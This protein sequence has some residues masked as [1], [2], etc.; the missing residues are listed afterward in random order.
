MDSYSLPVPDEV[1]EKLAEQIHIT[2]M[3]NRIKEGWTYGKV[4]DENKKQTP[5]IVPYDSLPESEKEY[6]RETARTTINTLYSLGFKIFKE[7]T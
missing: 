3:Q 6:D 5:C 4:R 7:A 2:W 1:L